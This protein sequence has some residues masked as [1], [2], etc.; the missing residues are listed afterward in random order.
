MLSLLIGQAVIRKHLLMTLDDSHR[1][2]CTAVSM[3]VASIA[4]YDWP[5]LL[6]NLL[7]LINDQ[8]NM[9]RVEGALKCLSLLSEDL[10]DAVVPTLVP[11]LFPT[12]H[13]IVSSSQSETNEMIN[14]FLK[15]WMD[16]FNIILREPVPSEDPDDWSIRMEEMPL[17]INN[18]C[19]N[20]ILFIK[21]RN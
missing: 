10:D 16:E 18:Y 7:K 8:T 21:E 5:E 15:P 20:N 14:S 3:A 19:L 1:K 9:K 17:M 2:I 4:V 11:I 12:L 13:K 6:P